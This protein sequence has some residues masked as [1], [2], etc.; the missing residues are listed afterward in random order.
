IRDPE[1][2]NELELDILPG[3]RSRRSVG[4]HPANYL[5]AFCDQVLHVQVEIP[6]AAKSRHQ[7]FDAV[8]TDYW[9]RS[10]HVIS[11]VEVSRD[12]LVDKL[13]FALVFHFLVEAS[14]Y[15][16]VCFGHYSSF[17]R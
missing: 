14:D 4:R 17:T 6:G 7:L 10:N 8:R 15:G 11:I 1:D 9:E 2:L 16:L 12:Q 5:V 13:Y 3:R